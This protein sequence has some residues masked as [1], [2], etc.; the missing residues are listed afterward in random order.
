MALASVQAQEKTGEIS[1]PS[2]EC[3]GGIH[4]DLARPEWPA[5]QP[6][7]LLLYGIGSHTFRLVVVELQATVKHLG[8]HGRERART[9]PPD[10]PQSLYLPSGAAIL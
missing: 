3:T 1:E 5:T 10:Q 6:R 4:K 9:S 8:G 2:E 7:P